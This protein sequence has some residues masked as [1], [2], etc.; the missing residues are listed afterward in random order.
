MT[1]CERFDVPSVLLSSVVTVIPTGARISL[2]APL[3][4][5]RART[6]LIK[7]I[8]TALTLSC[9]QDYFKTSMKA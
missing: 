7:E 5:F 3:S 4:P 8:Q 1:D 9:L 6:L 2:S